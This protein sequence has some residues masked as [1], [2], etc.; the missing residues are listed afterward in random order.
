MNEISEIGPDLAESPSF[1]DIDELPLPYAEIDAQGVI[2]R[3]NHA[4]RALHH[5]EQGE[6]VGMT[7]WTLMAMDEK[8]FSSAAFH[9]QM[10]SGEEP[11]VMCR[12]IFDR[13]GRFRTYEFHRSLMRDPEGRP[14]GMRLVFADVT[15][16]KKT[17]DDARHEQH[18]L[19]SALSSLPD[20]VIL[21]DILGVVRFVNPAAEELSGFAA[22]ELAGKVIDEAMPMLAYEARDGVALDRRTAIEKRCSGIAT[23][24]SRNGK[25]VKV[26]MKTSP[27]M[28]QDTGSVSGVAVV[29][30]KV[31]GAP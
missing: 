19:A 2:T 14:A 31:E 8:E 21:T 23:L 27:I 12:S 18:W 30:R 9:S 15:E 5:P 1:L 4:A 11:P 28:D 22:N 10:A 13:S 25:K 7:G 29:L 16:S 17:F 6:L 24:V 20:A 3:A 26:E